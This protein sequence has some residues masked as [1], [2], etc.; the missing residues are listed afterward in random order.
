M[1]SA[2]L[3][4]FLRLRGGAW[5]IYDLA[6]SVKHNGDRAFRL[7][8]AETAL[9]KYLECCQFADA[10]LEVNTMM[11]GIDMEHD[12]AMARLHC[13]TRVDT[14]LVALSDKR[15]KESGARDYALVPLAMAAVEKAEKLN[16]T[17]KKDVM[18]P[19]AIA[20]YYHLLGIAEL[21]LEHPVKAGK[22]F[23]KAYAI[24]KLPQ[25]KAGWELAKTWKEVS[26]NEREVRLGSL[27]ASM[28]KKPLRVEH[29]KEYGTPE[30]ASELWVMRQF[31]FQGPIPYEDRIK[32][33]LA[34]I[35]TTKPHPNHPLP[36]PRTATIGEV[37]P[38]V[39]TKYVDRLRK[40]IALPIAQ[41]KLMGQVA[42]N[43]EEIGETSIWDDPDR[44]EQ[45]ADMLKKKAGI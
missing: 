26:K 45:L 30:V 17:A 31:G 6:V 9:S 23:V 8:K 1:A 2:D 5:E 38:D 16:K 25:H 34:I 20:R 44:A 33:V 11:I 21:G 14:S 18:P 10:A 28:P 15:K 39:L 40:Q 27:L 32:P 22:S 7:G 42:L 12:H 41:G 4:Y 29:T 35:M 36:G 37:K 13:I 43:A 19:S 3:T 24:L